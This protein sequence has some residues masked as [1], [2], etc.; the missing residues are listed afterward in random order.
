M[1][2]GTHRREIMYNDFVLIGPDDDPA[3]IAEMTTVAEALEAISSAEINSR[4][5]P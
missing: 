3:G 1:S 5:I 2:F 4:S